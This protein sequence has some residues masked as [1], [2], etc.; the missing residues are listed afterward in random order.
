MLRPTAFVLLVAWGTL[1]ATSASRPAYAAC[2]DPATPGVDWHRCMMDER[3]L[4]GIDITG[5]K[6]RDARLTR[7]DLS[8]S[9][10]D[11]IDGRR[12]KFNSATLAGTSF[13]EARLVEADFT[14]ADLTG[15]SFKGSDLRRAR[16]FRAILRGADFTGARMEGADL[17]NADLSGATWTDGKYVCKEGSIGQ[18]K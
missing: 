4:T 6:L 13:N 15:A 11:K 8:Q 7:A 14:K 12:A 3:P 5:A 9:L 10:L 2:T 18:C 16:L 17:L 1:A